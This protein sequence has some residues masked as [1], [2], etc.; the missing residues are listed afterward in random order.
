MTFVSPTDNTWIVTYSGIVDTQ[1]HPH[2]WAEINIDGTL[3]IFD[4][5]ME[6]EERFITFKFGNYYMRTYESVS[7][8][9][10]TRG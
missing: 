4:P 5:T 1:R 9:S 10:Y 8:W 2:G 6:N 7:N 3:Y